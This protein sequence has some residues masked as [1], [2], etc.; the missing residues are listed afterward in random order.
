M[1]GRNFIADSSA[2]ARTFNGGGGIEQKFDDF[3]EVT[4]VE[5]GEDTKTEVE[6][7]DYR[8]FPNNQENKHT[9]QIKS[10]TFF[11][12]PQNV[13]ITAKWGYSAACPA[14]I[15]FAATVLVAGITNYSNSSKGKVQSFGMGIYTLTYKDDKQL[16]DYKRIMGILRNYKQ[17][18]F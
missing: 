15:T 17:Y 2:S 8:I 10:G 12:G 18:H 6:D 11:R 3:I 14:D 5:L 7:G 4:K 1:T 16:Q 13:T 9:I